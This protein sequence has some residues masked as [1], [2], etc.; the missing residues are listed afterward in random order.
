[1]NNL[2]NYLRSK[3]IYNFE[4]HTQQVQPETNFLKNIVD[5]PNIKNVMEIGFNA[6]HSAE[7]FLST[8]K[9]INLI[10]FDIGVHDYLIFGKEFIDNTY[11][12]RHELI[13]GDSLKTIPEFVKNNDTKFDIIFIDG[14]HDYDTS[15]NDIINCKNLANDKTIVILD[16]TINNNMLMLG[17]NEGPTKAW[18]EAKKKN[19]VLETGSLDFC[20][21]RGLSWGKYIL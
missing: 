14:G 18:Q 16:D 11:P 20:Q 4:G 9:N 17:W 6:G 21:G 5:N 7:T 19:I 10:S 13:I 3:N 1:M 15:Y 12:N 2:N 8:N